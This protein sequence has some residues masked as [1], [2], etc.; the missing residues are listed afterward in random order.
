V[1]GFFYVQRYLPLAELAYGKQPA[2]TEITLNVQTAAVVQLTNGLFVL[3]TR[4]SFKTPAE[5]PDASAFRLI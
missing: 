5:Q 3:D 4:A 1:C 2:G